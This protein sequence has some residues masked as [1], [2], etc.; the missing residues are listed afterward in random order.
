MPFAPTTTF[1]NRCGDC[2]ALAGDSPWELW[3]WDFARA[4]VTKITRFS[5]TDRFQVFS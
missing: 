5:E 2:Y 4:W 3:Y 1:P